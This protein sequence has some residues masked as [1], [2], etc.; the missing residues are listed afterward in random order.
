MSNLS[1]HYAGLKLR[2]PLIIGSSGL[3][4][5]VDKNIAWEKAGC[6][7]IVLRSLFEEQIENESQQFLEKSDYS[8]AHDLIRNYVKNNKIMDYLDLIRE[9]KNRCSVPI[10]ASINCYTDGG[11]VEFASQIESAGADAL[12]LNISA[13]VADPT[14]HPMDSSERYIRIVKKIKQT[15]H[16][17]VIVKSSRL[18]NNI[19]WLVNQLKNNDVDAVVLFNKLYQPDINIDLMRVIS[20]PVFSSQG[21]VSETLRWLSLASS[22]VPGIDLAA[23]TG[24][25]DWK[26]VIKCLLVGASAVQMV[27]ALYQDRVGSLIPETIHQIEKWMDAKGFKDIDAFK[28]KLNAEPGVNATKFERA[29]FMKYFSSHE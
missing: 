23:S 19:P 5:S 13:I 7:A 1:I 15:V 21:D 4:A 11:W 20:G 8:S 18:F 17:P 27:S 24:V 3:T 9:S 6:G 2:N 29:Q 25:Q 10:I 26:D 22:Y 14:I 28:G 16:I 12:E